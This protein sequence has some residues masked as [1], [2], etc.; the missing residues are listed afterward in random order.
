MRHRM[1]GRRLGRTASHRH[2]LWRNLVTS[3]VEHGRLETT[4][5]K[6]K[7]MRPIVERLVT[8]GKKGGLHRRRRAA[9]WLR[10]RDLVRKLFHEIAP[11][12][13][14]RAGGYTRIVRTRR[15]AGDAAPMA[16]IEFLREDEPARKVASA[17][18]LREKGKGGADKDRGA[19]SRKAKDSPKAAAPRVGG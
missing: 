7:E 9:E 14:N 6:A 4:L 10:R 16:V 2:A 1:E 15:R 17:R 19:G 3:V 5:A 8:L 11:R 18:G 13:E 12:Y